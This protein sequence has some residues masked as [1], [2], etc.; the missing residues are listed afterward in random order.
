MT[1]MIFLKDVIEADNIEVGSYTYYAQECEED[2][3]ERD[4]VLYNRKGH[5][6]LK[7]GKF[8]SIAN[9]VEIIMGAANHSMASISTYP[10]NIVKEKWAKNFGM[11]SE[12][13]PDK[14]DT[15]IGHDVWIGQ[16][17]TIMPGVRIGNGAVIGS[18]AVV[19]KDIPPYAIAVGNPV[20]VISYRF[21]ENTIQFLETLK[22]WDLEEEMLDQAIPYL[23]SVHLEES[24]EA[25]KKLIDQSKKKV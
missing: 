3:F 20:K 17:A 2:D 5:G 13:M 18:K 24:K 19:A 23:T 21:D 10:F 9:G 14:G 12:D 16:K 11:T 25:L 15:I 4:H 22:W 6:K 8:C 7:I 1:K